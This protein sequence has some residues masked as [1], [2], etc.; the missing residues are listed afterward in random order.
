MLK[1]F[2]EYQNNL[3]AQENEGT[4]QDKLTSIHEVITSTFAFVDRIAVA[5]YE[6]DKELLKIF[7]ASC[8]AETPLSHYETAMK[9]APLLQ[10]IKNKG[11]ARVINDLDLFSPD[12]KVHKLQMSGL[13]YPASYIMPVYLHGDFFGF[14]LFNS[15][16]PDAFEENTLHQMDLFGHMISL[17]I[18]DELMATHSLNLMAQKKGKFVQQGDPA[19][20]SYID[21]V[22]RYARIIAERL[23]DKYDLNDDYIE[24]VALFSSLHD[25][26]KSGIP[27]SILLKPGVLSEDE[28]ELMK[29]HANKGRDMVDQL[30]QQFGADCLR[31]A[32]VLR[33][34]AQY[35]H[36]YMDGTGYPKGLKGEEI[37]LEAR[38]VAVADIFDALT[39]ARPYKEACS[40]DRAFSILREMAGNELDSDC[41]NALTSETRTVENIQLFYSEDRLG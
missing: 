18:M 8:Y 24:Q 28:F 22:S 41:V 7:I 36:E 33:N 38:I 25:I 17:M 35:H 30:L 10:E 20:G 11:K 26:G 19:T 34:I 29:T 40:N 14:I 1:K 16:L 15:G 5:V 6:N 27:D 21:R 23:A 2:A 3:A 9:D 39:S 37:P 4:L 13:R 31:H 32:S 12:N